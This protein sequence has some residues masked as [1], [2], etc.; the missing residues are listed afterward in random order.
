MKNVFELSATAVT[1]VK[2]STQ[3][4]G[5][6]LQ[7]VK[8]LSQIIGAAKVRHFHAQFAKQGMVE[9]NQTSMVF[10]Y[11]KQF[12]QSSDWETKVAENTTVAWTTLDTL[13]G[14]EAVPAD[15]N[16]GVAMSERALRTN[17]VD[18]VREARDQLTYYAGDVVDLEVRDTLVASTNQASS[19]SSGRGAYTVYGGDAKADS[20]LSTGDTLTPDMIVDA[21]TNLTSTILKYW[22]PSSPA[23][24]AINTDVT[25]N[26]WRS[27]SNEPFILTI[28][29][30]QE[31]ALLKDSQFMNF[32][33]YG[34]R[35]AIMEGEIGK[36]VGSKVISTANTKQ[37]SS[38][39]TAADG[40]GTA[41][42]Q[43]HRCVL[44]KSLKAMGLAWAQ[45]PR[46]RVFDY[47]S[48][49]QKRMV[50]DLAYKSVAIHKDAICY[51]DVTDA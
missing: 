3:L 23:A 7:P 51:L 37:F 8:W 2:G 30:E 19:G 14:A 22:A 43:G 12:K 40:G 1:N 24:E 38:G 25:A 18:L 48:D 39:G 15:N 5:Y 49:L 46:L 45:K 42:A 20:E 27:A 9:K 13:D 21:K 50:M 44:F 26:P 34:S 32:S 35:E 17:A 47:P 29:P 41:G 28:A 6:T 31:K 36:Y 33:E 16:A 10:P 4:A 11:Q